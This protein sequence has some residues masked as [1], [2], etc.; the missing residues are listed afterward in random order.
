MSDYPVNYY[1]Y[2][3]NQQAVIS[4]PSQSMDS[5]GDYYTSNPK[6]KSI[7]GNQ[8]KFDGIRH[9]YTEVTDKPEPAGAWPDYALVAVYSYE[10]YNRLLGNQDATE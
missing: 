5:Y 8:G 3:T 9:Q 1:W 7:L 10:D 4:Q 6:P 2:S